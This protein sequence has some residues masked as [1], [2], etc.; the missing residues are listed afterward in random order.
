MPTNE[1][2]VIRK[3]SETL[4]EDLR[5][6]MQTLNAPI[7]ATVIIQP[8]HPQLH[9]TDVYAGFVVEVLHQFRPDLKLLVL[10]SQDL[11]I[12]VQQN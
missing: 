5:M 9:I 8:K 4:R 3:R 1:L 12:K 2:D 6:D 10:P 11:E 7:G